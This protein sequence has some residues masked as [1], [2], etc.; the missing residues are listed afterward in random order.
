[1]DDAENSKPNRPIKTWQVVLIFLVFV[2]IIGKVSELVSPSD[3]S[4][5]GTTISNSSW[6]PKDFESWNGDIAYKW[7]DNP[8]CESDS[9][10]TAINVVT[11]IDCPNNLYAEI[12]L[13]DK[14]YVQYD[15]TNDS[16]GSLD[17]GSTA[18]LTFNFAA[19]SRFAHFKISKISCH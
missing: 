18:E 12:L 2:T 10:C 19:D 15:Y 1:M 3:S 5:S 11:N 6:I 4:S 9:V 13:Q 17:K 14:N 16:Q 7:V 8:T